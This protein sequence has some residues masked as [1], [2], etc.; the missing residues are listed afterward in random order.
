MLD[1]DGT[2]GKQSLKPIVHYHSWR[3]GK[4]GSPV[5]NS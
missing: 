5:I 3:V 2:N 4:F 1:S